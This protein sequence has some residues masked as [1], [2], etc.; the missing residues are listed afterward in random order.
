MPHDPLHS[1]VMRGARRSLKARTQ[2]HREVDVWSHRHHVQQRP[3][4]AMVLLLINGFSFFVS[5]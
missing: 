5:V 4:H 3:D 2:T 1:L